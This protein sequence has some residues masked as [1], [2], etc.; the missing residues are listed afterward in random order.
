MCLVCLIY[1]ERSVTNTHDILKKE[2]YFCFKKYLFI[3]YTF[4]CVSEHECY[5]YGSDHI[6]QLR[7]LGALELELEAVVSHPLWV[8]KTK[9]RSRTLNC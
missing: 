6:S 2:E 1:L 3:I 8:L 5:K 7:A 9:F 4:I